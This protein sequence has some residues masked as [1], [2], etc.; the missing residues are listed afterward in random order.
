MAR[1]VKLLITGGSGFLGW[2]L[3]KY[4]AELYEVS[5]TYSQ[6]PITIP[7]CQEYHIDLQNQ[8]EV[9]DL[10]EDLQPEVLIHTAALTNVDVCEKRRSLAHEINVAATNHLVKCAEELGCRFVY[11]STD[12]VFDGQKGNYSET[13]RPNPINYYGETKFLGEKAV[14]DISTNYLVVRM[15]LMYGNGNGVNGCF[16]DWLRK[17]IEK[18]QSVPLYTDQYR[19]PLFV[20]D[21]IR[22]LLE[23]I[24]KPVKNKILHLAGRERLNRYDFGQKFIKIFGY[25]DQWLRPTKIQDVTSSGQRGSDCSLNTKAIQSLLSFQLSDVNTGLQQMK[26]L[27]S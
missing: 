27:M 18:K 24:E 21:G 3:A 10:L 4:A 23:L 7:E 20:F 8:S 22:A 15:A 5:F 14:M 6:H 9:E 19:T 2:N 17:G 25:S 11:I 1:Y 13:D 26:K 12:L 16:T